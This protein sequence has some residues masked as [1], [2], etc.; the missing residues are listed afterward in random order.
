MWAGGDGETHALTVPNTDE[1][2]DVFRR[3]SFFCWQ[4]PLP[5]P[6]PAFTPNLEAPTSCRERTSDP[7]APHRDEALDPVDAAF[8]DARGVVFEADGVANLLQELFGAGFP[9]LFKWFDG[10]WGGDI[11]VGKM[12]LQ[13]ILKPDALR[14]PPQLCFRIIP[15][16]GTKSGMRAQW[17]SSV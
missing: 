15:H 7:S 2:Q 4:L 9:G 3:R 17:L 16:R 14:I 6:L 13:S 8:L 10:S 1:G 12:A 11:L 5:G